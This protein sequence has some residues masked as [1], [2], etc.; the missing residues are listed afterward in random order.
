VSEKDLLVSLTITSRNNT[1][2]RRLSCICAK[3]AKTVLISCWYILHVCVLLIL[4]SVYNS[5]QQ[6]EYIDLYMF[7]R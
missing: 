3:N 6:V 4:F 2:G 7:T 1:G 5:Q